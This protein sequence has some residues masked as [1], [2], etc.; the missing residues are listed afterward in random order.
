[1]ELARAYIALGVGGRAQVRLARRILLSL[2]TE[3]VIPLQ[4]QAFT[5]GYVG[6]GY[7]SAELSLLAD[8][9]LAFGIW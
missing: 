9:G 5:V 2:R 1:M 3:A 4:R 7:R 8:V 6:A